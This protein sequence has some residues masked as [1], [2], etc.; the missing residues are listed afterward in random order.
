MSPSN[1]TNYLA[2]DNLFCE[3]INSSALIAQPWMFASTLLAHVV[4]PLVI[5]L[6]AVSKSFT[7]GWN[8]YRGLLLWLV[9]GVARSVYYSLGGT[10]ASQGI[11]LF[12]WVV[13]VWSL[14]FAHFANVHVRALWPEQKKKTSVSH[15]LVLFL[16]IFWYTILLGAA[17]TETRRKVASMLNGWVD[18]KWLHLWDYMVFVAGLVPVLVLFVYGWFTRSNRELNS[19]YWITIGLGVLVGVFFFLPSNFC[20][21]SGIFILG[22]V[23]NILLNPLVQLLLCLSTALKD[24]T[25]D[26]V[27]AGWVGRDSGMF[28]IPFMWKVVESTKGAYGKVQQAELL[29]VPRGQ[30]LAPNG[31]TEP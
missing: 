20:N 27:I 1:A 2:I 19:T 24:P 31:Y 13:V 23:G 11:P 16:V 25:R 29:V 18:T 28:R 5:L 6:Y 8:Y 21:V 12:A 14:L 15:I 7:G 4:A 17:D 3:D 9:F 30:V 22:F 10:D 26:V